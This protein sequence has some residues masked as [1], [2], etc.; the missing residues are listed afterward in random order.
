[1]GIEL[2]I[3][4]IFSF[5]TVTIMNIWLKPQNRF[6]MFFVGLW[7]IGESVLNTKYFIIKLPNMGFDLQPHRIL[8]LLCSAA[9][10]IIGVARGFGG[11]KWKSTE[12]TLVTFFFLFILTITTHYLWQT[13]ISQKDF[14]VTLTTWSAF[15]TVYF[16]MR[17][18][19]TPEVVKYIFY[20]TLVLCIATALIGLA[21][22]FISQTF[23]VVGDLRAAF[24]G[25][26]R[27]NG[28]FQAEYYHA[29]FLIIGIIWLLFYKGV[30]VPP[31]IRF[32]LTALFLLSLAFTFHR[33]SYVVAAFVLLVF[34]LVEAKKAKYLTYGAFTLLSIIIV[35]GFLD[36]LQIIGT[37]ESFV[38]ERLMDDTVTGR[39]AIYNMVINR[40]PDIWL[41]GVGSVFSNSYYQDIVSTGEQYAAL[42]YI[43]GIHNLYLNMGY[44]YGVPTTLALIAFLIAL[45][46]VYF[47]KM[48]NHGSEYYIPL[49][50]AALFIIA[51]LTN[52]FYLNTELGIYLGILFG[53]FSAL[54]PEETPEEEEEEDEEAGAIA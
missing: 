48:R 9:L 22:F 2:L 8:F 49:L 47:A 4:V 41:L 45:V 33:M 12:V 53:T 16:V 6:I 23:F 31:F 51:N 14:L 37:G 30:D 35:G 7:I 21:Q 46:R 11:V 40:L 43:G 39:F 25:K 18:I 17:K 20:L 38:T 44:L 5:V 29:Y 34:N 54:H 1:M 52:W 32:A 26:F 10:I 27:V 3:Y 24:A 28:V 13:T 36:I 15:L 42:G 19:S 50:S